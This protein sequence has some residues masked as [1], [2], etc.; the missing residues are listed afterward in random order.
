MQHGRKR[1]TALVATLIALMTAL[2]TVG[3][4]FA[5]PAATAKP[6][7]KTVKKQVEKLDQ[8]A[9]AA[10]ERYNDAK[11]RLGQTRTALSSLNSDLGRQK[12]VVGTMRR[13]VA[14][15]VVDQYQGDALS[16][17]SQV[18][19]STNP[20]AF[21][22]NLNAVSAYNS[23]RGQVMTQFTNELDRLVLRK[24]AVKSEAKRL[25]SLEG[26]MAR[27][28][29]EI[30]AK[31]S[32]AHALLD[33]LEAAQQAAILGGDYTGAVPTFS[34][35]SRAAVALRYAM[36]QIGKSYVYGAA[37][38]GAFDCSG[39]MMRA[40]GAAGVG[41]PHSSRAQQGSGMRVSE[42]QLQPGD[43]VFYYSPVSHVGMYIGNG[44]IVNAEN[45]RAGVRVTGLHTMPYVGAVRPG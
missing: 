26:Q 24:S 1:T 4:G 6:D 11:V 13:Q 33:K 35:G 5:V 8:Q 22:D 31:A 36:A 28:K 34:G 20:D 14:A 16:T 39:L 30:D 44:L 23:Q 19:L 2:V 41:L 7:L 10:S 27:E 21:L 15:M 32:R 38:P 12:A 9:E 37:G 40:W 25:Q 18:V 42:G 3:I 45:P 43:L 29:S 17:T